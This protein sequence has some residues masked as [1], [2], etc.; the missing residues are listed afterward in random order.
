MDEKRTVLVQCM[1]LYGDDDA[2]FVQCKD[3]YGHGM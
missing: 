1:Q 3:V 2:G